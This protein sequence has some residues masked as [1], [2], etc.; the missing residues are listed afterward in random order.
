MEEEDILGN[1][2]FFDCLGL[3][4][5]NIEKNITSKENIIN[6]FNLLEYLLQ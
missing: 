4:A 2:E 5:K 6:Y 3:I 1:P